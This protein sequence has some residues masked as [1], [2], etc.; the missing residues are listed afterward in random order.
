[1]RAA[2]LLLLS[3]MQRKLPLA[4]ALQARTCACMAGPAL[5]RAGDIMSAVIA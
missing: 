5:S 1:M 4:S 3:C 2:Q